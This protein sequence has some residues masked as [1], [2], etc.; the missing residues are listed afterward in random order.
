MKKSIIIKHAETVPKRVNFLCFY[1]F[2]VFC[3]CC[4]CCCC[5]CCLGLFLLGFVS[6]M[7]TCSRWLPRLTKAIAYSRNNSYANKLKPLENLCPQPRWQEGGGG[8][9]GHRFSRGFKERTYGNSTGQLKNIWKFYGSWFLTLEFPSK[10]CHT[11][12][13]NSQWWKLVF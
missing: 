13:Q 6:G 8:G 4:C 7:V 5:C 11:I 12:L 1:F 3:W 9:W 2:F 10:A